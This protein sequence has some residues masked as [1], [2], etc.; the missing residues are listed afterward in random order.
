MQKKLLCF[1]F[2]DKQQQK[3]LHDL[4]EQ[5]YKENGLYL[6]R[7]EITRANPVLVQTNL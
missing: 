6:K 2:K 1:L 4:V 5:K 3:L 7:K